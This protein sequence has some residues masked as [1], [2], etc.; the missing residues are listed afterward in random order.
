MSLD[1]IDLIEV[2][3]NDVPQG[4]ASGN[5]I[6]FLLILVFS[7]KATLVSHPV[8]LRQGQLK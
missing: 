5:G 6:L 4:P 3:A 7:L 1:E 2:P 8:L